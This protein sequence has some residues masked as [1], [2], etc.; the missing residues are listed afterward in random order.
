[1][2]IIMHKALIIT[3]SRGLGP[4]L[5][6]TSSE[7]NIA[8]KVHFVTAGDVGENTLLS[9]C[10][11]DYISAKGSVLTSINDEFDYLIWYTV[12]FLQK[13]FA[14][15]SDEELEV[16]FDLHYR[17]PLKLIQQ[18]HKKKTTPYHLIVIASCSSWRMRLHEAVY[19]SLC[20][21]KAT[22]A[23]TFANELCQD[24]PGSKV[25]LV[26]PGGLRTPLYYEN[27]EPVT[28]YLDTPE[29]ARFIWHTAKL[30]TNNFEEIQYLRNKSVKTMQNPPLIE[31]GSRHPETI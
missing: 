5:A 20:A 22:F 23:R 12:V 18:Q 1:M 29:L 4:E 30:Q 17:I 3:A 2:D 14:D 25:M 7:Y 6:N 27:D 28:G 31:F 21:A 13:K 19:C 15:T 8:S 9:T 16:L 11:P 24:L 26:N 10:E